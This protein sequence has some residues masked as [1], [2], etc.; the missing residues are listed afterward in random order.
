[1]VGG[2]GNGGPGW[3]GGPGGW[4]NGGPGWGGGPGGFGNGGPGWGGPPLPPPGG[5]PP[6]RAFAPRGPPPPWGGPPPGGIVGG[7][8]RLAG[9]FMG[10]GGEDI[11]NSFRVVAADNGIF[12]KDILLTEKQAHFL[13]NELGK[14]GVGSDVP[15]PV[16]TADEMS[17]K[18][19]RASVFF[20]ENPVQ[21]WD[22]PIPYTFDESLNEF[23]KNDIRGAIQEIEQRTCIRF[24]YVASATGHHIRY[25]KMDN[26]SFCGLSYIGRIDPANPVYLS[27]QCPNSRGI[28]VHETL[29]ALGLN[30]QHLRM[31]R[32]KHITMQ[33]SNI[34]P[35]LYDQF[36]VIDSKMFTS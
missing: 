34:N 33:W 19:K 32:D 24:T 11:V 20:E 16:L 31:D 18:F 1:F 28:A 4:G 6:P 17:A 14:A 21:K 5:P 7:V 25:Q 10:L 8:G 9:G 2:W 13:L 36:A 27:F 22:G 23:E 15:P 26:P 12:D 30:H 3:G 35:Q 29:H